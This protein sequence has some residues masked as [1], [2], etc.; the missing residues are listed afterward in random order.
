MRVVSLDANYAMN[1]ARKCKAVW[2]DG[3]RNIE[4]R[5][6]GCYDALKLSLEKQFEF[7]RTTKVSSSEENTK[8]QESKSP[9]G[10]L[11]FS[12]GTSENQR[13]PTPK[14]RGK[15]KSLASGSLSEVPAK[16]LKDGTIGAK[17]WLY[18]YSAKNEEGKWK[19]LKLHVPTGK[20]EDVK[21]AIANRKGYHFIISNILGK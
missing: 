15:S 18:S 16:K 9:S 19:T 7:W 4:Q 2:S 12:E 3:K 11:P 17:R 21:Q 1:L 13:R 14:H 10:A 20:L 6:Q 5:E 8:K